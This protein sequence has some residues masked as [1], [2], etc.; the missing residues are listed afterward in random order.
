MNGG[1]PGLLGAIRI[2]LVRLHET[3]M[4]VLFPRQLD[5][6]QVLGKW[7]PETALQ[8]IAYYGWGAIG[9]PLVAIA[10]P[11]LLVGFATRFYGGKLNSAATRLGIIGVVLVSVVVWGAL[12]AIAWDQL[13]F[14]EFLAVAA[15]SSVATVSA[16][17][18]VFFSRIGG[19]ATTVVFAYPAAMTALF[20]PPVVAALFTPVLQDVIL[21]PSYQLAIVILDE[22]LYVG[23]INEY[24][25]ENFTLEGVNYVFM[26]L[27]ISI[28][29]GWLLG[30]LVAL[31]N[32]IRPKSD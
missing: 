18:A 22:V 9:L 25:R 7:K 28:P 29:I 32:L 8:K 3:W 30:L 4:E 5:P 6:S 27:G 20:L 24:L 14:E 16:A 15:A 31:A 17:L 26:W 23:G 1:S 11:L 21:D 13:P 10:Y 2:D 12:S 19:R